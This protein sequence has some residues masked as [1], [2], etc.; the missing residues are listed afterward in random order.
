[1]LVLLASILTLTPIPPAHAAYLGLLVKD[2]YTGEDPT[3]I[4]WMILDSLSNGLRKVAAD[5]ELMTGRNGEVIKQLGQ[6]NTIAAQTAQGAV[7]AAKAVQPARSIGCQ[8]TL[9][10]ASAAIAQ[11][12]VS[13]AGETMVS[14]VA[15]SGSAR[16][17]SGG[18]MPNNTGPASQ[19]T[20]LACM[21]DN[22]KKGPDGT[23]R[24]SGKTDDLH[25][26][27]CK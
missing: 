7:I 5:I 8:T 15:G 11:D 12:A 3:D 9:A 16:G 2:L 20:T 24:Y 14:M 22:I 26:G 23:G 18:T 19:A 13:Q 27:Q 21:R 25:G 1:M 6:A 17:V 10:A 4:F